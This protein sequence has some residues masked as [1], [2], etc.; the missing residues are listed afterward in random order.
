MVRT[1]SSPALPLV[2]ALLVRVNAGSWGVNPPTVISTAGPCSANTTQ[3]MVNNTEV[4]VGKSLLMACT[5]KIPGLINVFIKFEMYVLKGIPSILHIKVCL[6]VLGSC[7]AYVKTSVESFFVLSTFPQVVSLESV[8]V[9][10]ED[11]KFENEVTLPRPGSYK[12]FFPIQIDLHQ[13]DRI[14]IYACQRSIF[15]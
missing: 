8:S 15:W 3:I 1:G 9:R 11:Y 7:M 4:N 2:R 13:N 5:V 14:N 6:Q 10:T 12:S